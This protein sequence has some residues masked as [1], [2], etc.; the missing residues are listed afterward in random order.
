MTKPLLIMPPAVARWPAFETLLATEEPIWMED[1][2]RRLCEGVEGAR[3]AFAVIPDGGR[4]L[5]AA[6]IRRRHQVGVLGQLFTHPEHRQRG[7]ARRLMQTLLSWFDMTGGRWLLATAGAGV[8]AGFLEHFGFRV[9][10]GDGGAVALERSL[11]SVAGEPAAAMAGE[12]TIAPLGRADWPSL[13]ALLMHRGGSD[14]R[15]AAQETALT[16]ERTALELV[17]QADRGL[18]ALLGAWR[19]ERLAGMASVAIDQLGGRT[20]AMIVP[21]AGAPENLRPAAVALA[22]ARGY[23]QVEFPLEAVGAGFDVG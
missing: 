17:E 10:H 22:Q 18:C 23:E 6:C 9:L 14:R 16:A 8:Y 4:V 1:L 20:Y 5:A 3:D 15:V 7:H 2:R 13:V 19:D 11:A 12:A 21:H